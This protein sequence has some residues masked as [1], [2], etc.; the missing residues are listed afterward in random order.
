MD[1]TVSIHQANEPVAV[2]SI[3]GSIDASNFVEVVTRAQEI[4]NKPARNLIID[5]SDVPFIS[6]AGIVAIHNIALL[7]SGIPQ[8]IKQE[9]G[10]VVSRTDFTHSSNARKYVK[11]LNPQPR[12]D[13]TIETAGMK[14]FFKVFHDLESA[15]QS[16]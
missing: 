4:Y 6:S 13:K 16:F 9:E 8:E 15:L 12:V 14:L 2:M 1:I 7:Y 3:K 10:T 11:L 5:L